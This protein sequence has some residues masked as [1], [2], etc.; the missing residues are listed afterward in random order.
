MLVVF[1][2]PVDDGMVVFVAVEGVVNND[3]FE[4][5]LVVVS[6]ADSVVFD[7]A[8][9]VEF[10]S[11]AF[12]VEFDIIFVVN[13]EGDDVAVVFLLVA[14]VGKVELLAFVWLVLCKG[15]ILVDCMTDDGG[16][17]DKVVRFNVSVT[18]G[19]LV[20]VDA[21]VSVA[22]ILFDLDGIILVGLVAVVEFIGNDSVT[23]ERFDS[24]VSFVVIVVTMNGF[25][26]FLW[27]WVEAGGLVVSFSILLSDVV[28]CI[29]LFEF[30]VVIKG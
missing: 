28:L 14:A 21:V 19:L 5:L 10:L 23:F 17:V 12:I 3:V 18:F 11:F 8:L 9:A 20:S 4:T 30:D 6:V 29:V 2:G 27:A 22:L 1:V 26:A 16:D 24:S 7:I 13:T 15:D 25:V